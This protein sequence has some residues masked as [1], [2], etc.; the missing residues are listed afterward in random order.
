VLAAKYQLKLEASY[1]LIAAV[2]NCAS[3]HSLCSPL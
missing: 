2:L 3:F 1:Q